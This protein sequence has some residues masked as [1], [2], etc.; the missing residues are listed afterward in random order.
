[1][2]RWLLVQCDAAN[3]DEDAYFLAYGPA[4][5]SAEELVRV[6]DTRWQIEVG[7]AQAKGEVGLD[8][9]EVRTW[10]AWH[11]MSPSA[12]WRM[13]TWSPCAS[14]PDRKKLVKG[15]G[16]PRPPPAHRAGGAPAGARD[17]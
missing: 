10:D 7:F 14:R 11:G 6:C 3:P 13:P 16:T 1:M 9:D 4:D 15:G 8:H 5:T 12:S 2:A 17:G